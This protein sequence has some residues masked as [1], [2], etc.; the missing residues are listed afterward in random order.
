MSKEKYGSISIKN[1]QPGKSIELQIR[2]GLKTKRITLNQE[3]IF[4]GRIKTDHSNHIPIDL[5]KNEKPPLL[6]FTRNSSDNGSEVDLI[7]NYFNGD[8]W[9]TFI[10]I[11]KTAQE[12]HEA[13]TALNEKLSTMV[14]S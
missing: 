14:F 8:T 11:K 10:S 6:A 4:L 13:M 7:I 9:Q 1:F 5:L 2:H 3:G 12:A